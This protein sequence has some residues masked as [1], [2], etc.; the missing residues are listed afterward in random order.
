MLDGFPSTIPQ[1]EALDRSTG[2][3]LG[4]TIDYAINVEVPDENIVNRMGGRQS[5]PGILRRYLSYCTCSDRGKR[6]SAIDAVQKLVLRD[7]DKPETVKNRLDVY[8]NQTQPLIEYY[9]K[10]GM[11]AEVD[12]TQSME[13][14]FNAIVEDFR[15][16][17][18]SVTIKSA[19]EIEL[20]R[21]GRKASGRGSQRDW[22]RLLKPGMSTLD[23][24]RIG[25]E[26]HPGEMAAFPNFLNY[27]GYPASI[28]VSVNDEVV[29][30]IPHKR[31]HPS[32]GRHRQS[33]CRPDLQGIPLRRSP[34]PFGRRM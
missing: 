16:V 10:Q 24:D 19:R 7:D 31:S 12:G 21:R 1:A 28:C 25:E 17:K 29:H 18:M 13:D 4:E 15:S 23:I 34:D 6:E 9:T 14:V 11:L 3:E 26:A 22:R 2:K 32:G 27:N 33:G 5:V 30:G 20:M 8:H